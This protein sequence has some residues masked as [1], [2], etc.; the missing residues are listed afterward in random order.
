[1]ARKVNIGIIGC[2]NISGAYVEGCRAFD[3]LEVYACADLI[4]ERARTLAG[5]YEIPKIY[6][7]DDLLT[8]DDIEIVV[9]LTVPRAHAAVSLAAIEAGKHVY[10]EK[11]LAITRADGRQVLM[12]ASQ[13]GVRVGCAPDS[14]LGG[15]LQTCRKIID[16]ALIGEP[17]G[18]NAFFLSSGPES[19][20]PNPEFF[21]KAG[22]G[23]LFDMGPYYVTALVHLLGPV[24]RV[25]GASRI[26]FA[27]RIIG[28]PARRGERFPAEVPTYITGLMEF[29][30]G[31]IGAFVASFDVS[32]TSLPHIEILG[33]EGTLIAP[34]PNYF[35]GPVR[36]RR[37]GSEDWDSIPLTHSDTVSRGIGVAD[38]AYSLVSGR[39]HR[40]NGHIAFHVLEIMAAIEEA[41]E[42]SSYIDLES[43]CQRPE[44]LPMGLASG[45]LDA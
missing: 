41:A 20:H 6:S 29:V 27:E 37:S 10:S 36:I 16:D 9:N 1:M 21:Y 26:T 31:P 24:K 13:R 7:V 23:P 22:A 19:W 8:N 32:A 33:S 39:T 18:A 34:N 3:I 30:S 40:A 11:P 35:G 12:E 42:C 38:M 17:V 14:F 15:G 43:S 5:E 2:G 25:T 28:N 44:P 4:D 45:K